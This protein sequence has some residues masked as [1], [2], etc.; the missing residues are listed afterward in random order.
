MYN[1]SPSRVK[2]PVMLN[3]L[4]RGCFICGRTY[5][6]LNTTFPV[7][8][9]FNTQMEVSSISNGRNPLFFEFVG[10][11]VSDF[12]V[13]WD[14][15]VPYSSIFSI[16][17]DSNGGVLFWCLLCSSW[18][19]PPGIRPGN[20]AP[21]CWRETTCMNRGFS[22][23]CDSI[24]WVLRRKSYLHQTILSTFLFIFIKLS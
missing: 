20:E 4:S 21:L 22:L 8:W 18:G 5:M 10:V 9:G 7:F 24:T 14:R 17:S 1:F 16:L 2:H 6:Y 19:Y 23:T 15:N 3:I 13:P 11:R 12:S